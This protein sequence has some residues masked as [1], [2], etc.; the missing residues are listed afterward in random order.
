MS[1]W[2]RVE[3]NMSAIPVAGIGGLGMVALA[4]VIAL[5]FPEARLLLIIGLVGG[6]LL[7]IG[8]IARR[9]RRAASHRDDPVSVFHGRSD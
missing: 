7:G 2:P 3:I 4:G 1:P 9:R 5:A 8:I 6:V